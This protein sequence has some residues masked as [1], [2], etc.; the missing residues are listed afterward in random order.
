MRPFPPYCLNYTFLNVNTG[1]FYRKSPFDPGIQ[2]WLGGLE[3]SLITK[4]AS[5][6]P[7]LPPYPSR[8]KLPWIG[9]LSIS[10]GR[11]GGGGG[12]NLIIY[13]RDHDYHKGNSNT[14]AA[15]SISSSPEYDGLEGDTGGLLSS[16]PFPSPSL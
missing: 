2:V 16:L 8:L 14:A 3:E 15:A 9:S 12:G 6:L 11:E 1:F 13:D 4:I 7:R 10:N 5:Y